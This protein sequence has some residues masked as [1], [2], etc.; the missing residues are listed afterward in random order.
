MGIDAISDENWV[1]GFLSGVGF[2]GEY[3]AD[4]LNGMDADG[5]WAWIDNYCSAN[6]IKDIADAAGQF[7]F[8][9]PRFAHPR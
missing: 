6:P 2:V 3:G 1:T 9:H 5:V 8:A 4:P 7:Y